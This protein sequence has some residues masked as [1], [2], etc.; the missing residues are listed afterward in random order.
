MR[1]AGRRVWSAPLHQRRI[2]TREPPPPCATLCSDRGAVVDARWLRGRRGATRGR[3]AQATRR[4]HSRQGRRGRDHRSRQLHSQGIPRQRELRGAARS[5]AQTHRRADLRGGVHRGE[6]VR[7]RRRRAART[8]PDGD[9]RTAHRT[10]FV[11]QLARNRRRVYRGHHS[12]PDPDLR[13]E[14]RADRHA[15]A[16]RLRQRPRAE[17]RQRRRRVGNRRVCG[18]ARCGG[19]IP[20]AVP[21][22][23]RGETT[24]GITGADAQGR[25]IG[26]G[27]P[28]PRR[29]SPT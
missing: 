8:R 11:R 6:D 5:F 2:A 17:D 26:Q 19:E 4:A 7:Q 27:R 21:G 24:A 10:V 29:R 9:L 12:L 15:D 22:T 20:H 18:H 14:R 28:K 23:G 3:T 16:H 13:A 25:S 1:D